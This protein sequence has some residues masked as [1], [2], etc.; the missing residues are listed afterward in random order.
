MNRLLDK[1]E[2]S[3]HIIS[4]YLQTA[5]ESL[6]LASHQCQ[7]L[8][9]KLFLGKVILLNFNPHFKKRDKLFK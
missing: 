3:Y 9:F 7:V 4:R 6:H 2:T 5:K 1:R 8:S